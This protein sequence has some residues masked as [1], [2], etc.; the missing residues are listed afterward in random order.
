MKIIKL[1]A[2]FICII[3]ISCGSKS[4]APSGKA[5]ILKMEESSDSF[6]S[7][8]RSK[9][10][11]PQMGFY[12]KKPRPTPIAT[13]TFKIRYFFADNRK[14]QELG[15]DQTTTSPQYNN[16]RL[17]ES[18]DKMNSSF[19]KGRLLKRKKANR[20]NDM[21]SDSFAKNPNKKER[22]GLFK[23]K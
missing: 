6:G 16:D 9:K 20:A 15:N 11:V 22:R 7:S 13:T 23:R 17:A 8:R 1:I 19:S 4:S 10:G 14:K 18:L 2:P 12:Y 3:A 21:T 5:R